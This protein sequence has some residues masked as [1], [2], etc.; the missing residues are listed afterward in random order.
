M[1]LTDM[2]FSVSRDGGAYEWAGHGL[3]SFFAQTQNIW[4]PTQWQLLWD[5]I[6]FVRLA[7]L[8]PCLITLADL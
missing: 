3:S 6:R 5:I 2:S 8:K 7:H 4:D 1:V